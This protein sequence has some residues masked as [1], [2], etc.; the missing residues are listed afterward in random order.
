[1][2]RFIERIK[3]KVHLTTASYRQQI[4]LLVVVNVSNTHSISHLAAD[5]RLL[6]VAR[7]PVEE[8]TFGQ[9]VESSRKERVIVDP[10]KFLSFGTSVSF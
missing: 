2:S 6:H 8:F 3:A 1:L 10:G 5:Q 4:V 9:L 7:V